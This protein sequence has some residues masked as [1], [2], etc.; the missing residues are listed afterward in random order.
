MA[1]PL[2]LEGLPICL[3]VAFCKS[4]PATIHWQEKR[5]SVYLS[6]APLPRNDQGAQ[7]N[8]A[9]SRLPAALG[10][11]VGCAAVRLVATRCGA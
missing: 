5:V 2:D 8:P 4:S 10:R 7:E 3:C 9:T 1:P 6:T 11:A